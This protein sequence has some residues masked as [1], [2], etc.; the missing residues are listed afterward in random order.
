MH[1]WPARTSTTTGRLHQ[2]KNAADQVIADYEY[3]LNGNRAANSYH[4]NLVWT[5]AIYDDQDRLTSYTTR[6]Q[7]STNTTTTRPGNPGRRGA[8]G[9]TR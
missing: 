9:E 3:D 2:V 1:P 7:G 5:E 6:E 8:T 4:G